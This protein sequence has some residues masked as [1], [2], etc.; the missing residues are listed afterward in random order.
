MKNRKREIR[1]SGSVR[2]EAGEPP[3]L[4][5]RRQFLHL[6]AGAAALPLA[7]PIAQAQAY[8]TRPVRLI[9]PFAPGGPTDL[10]ARLIAQKLSEQLGKQ[11]YVENIAGASGNIG[12]S[13]A[14]RAAP[15]G[16]TILVN[17]SVFVTNPAFVGKAP[18]DPINDFAP[19]A[20]PV[21]SAIT[22]VVHPSVPARTVS[23]LVALIRSN[24]QRYS[25]ASAGTGAQPHLTFEQFKLSLGLD[26]VHVPFNGAGPA[27]AAVAAGH[28]PIGIVSLPPAVQLIKNGS[29][30]ALALT[31]KTRA[32]KL[33]DVPTVA[34]A[35]YPILEGDQWLGVL[36]PAA[37]PKEIIVILNRKIGEIVSDAGMQE[38]LEELDFYRI[39]G[40]P[41]EFTARIKGEL[42]IWSKVVKAAN[43]KPD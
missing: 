4:L 11:F 36:M 15:D 30:R 33:P 10:F 5:G 43:I 22:L 14:A 32:Q 18:Y 38:R 13:Q 8:P 1:T 42:E 20:L 37:T 29:L 16:Y 24:P 6:A 9:V 39:N 12:T 27:V 34:E 21:A 2:D 41:D 26:V 17:V 23:D 25:Y 7:P 3:H 35:G 19:V 40:T 31:S 28:I